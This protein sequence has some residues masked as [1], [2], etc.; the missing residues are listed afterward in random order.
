M[1][2]TL[3]R[4]QQSAY[5]LGDDL[6]DQPV[7]LLVHEPA[8]NEADREELALKKLGARGWGR[9]HHFRHYYSQGWGEGTGKPLSPRSLE[10]FYQFLRAISFL[11]DRKPSL[12][13]TDAGHLELC[14]EDANGKAI[15]LEFTPTGAD[16]YLETEKREGTV[17]YLD[18]PSLA[19]ELE[20]R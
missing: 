16:F 6:R 3:S 1:I 7:S 11:P 9:L 20:T 12:F 5:F 15:Q 18:L 10:G 2:A 19:R 17:A 8:P 4:N 13:L 14:W